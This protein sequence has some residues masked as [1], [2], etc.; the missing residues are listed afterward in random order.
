MYGDVELPWSDTKLANYLCTGG[1]CKYKIV[2]KNGMNYDFILNYIMKDV[3][4]CYDKGACIVLG[5]ALLFFIYT[6]EGKT[7]VPLFLHHQVSEN[8]T[9]LYN[10]E[11][12]PNPVERIVLVAHGSDSKVFLD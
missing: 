6:P 2:K 1:P 11:L 12:M 8:Y 10:N 5:M 3:M 7:I 4:E 9:R